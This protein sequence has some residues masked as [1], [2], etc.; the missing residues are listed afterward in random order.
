M[1]TQRAEI[2]RKGLIPAVVQDF[3][4]EKR[5]S[6]WRYER[7]KSGHHTAGK[8]APASGPVPGRSCGARARRAAMCSMWCLSRR[9]ATATRWW[10]KSLRTVPPA[11]W[12][13]IPA[14]PICF[15]GTRRC[16]GFHW[17]RCTR[18][19]RAAMPSVP[20]AAIPPT[21]LKK[22]GEK[23]LKKVGEEC[24]EVIIRGHE[25]QPGGNHLRNFRPVLPCAGPDGRKKASRWMTSGPSWRRAMSLT[26]R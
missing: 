13:R 21:C 6:P 16:S 12:A 22:G 2:R 10:W 9:T 4:H 14:L 5:C 11:I 8:S 24:T 20:R 1:T 19:W 7:R 25:G 18:C 23:I 15:S 3:L 26:I 17:R